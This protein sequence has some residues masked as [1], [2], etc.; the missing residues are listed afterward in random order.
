M[1]VLKALFSK[2]GLK[3]REIALKFCTMQKRTK[4]TQAFLFS[5]KVLAAYHEI[6]IYLH[7]HFP[8]W[9]MQKMQNFRSDVEV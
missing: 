9:V 2:M 7:K 5:D 4:V 8:F 1:N 3:G 6:E